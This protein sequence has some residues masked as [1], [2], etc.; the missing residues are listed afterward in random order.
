M[1]SFKALKNHLCPHICTSYD[2]HRP[3][4]LQ[5]NPDLHPFSA[6]GAR[7]VNSV[8][9]FTLKQTRVTLRVFR[10]S[11]PVRPLSEM[12]RSQWLISNRR[13]CVHALYVRRRR[14]VWGLRTFA[15]IDKHARP[16]LSQCVCSSWG[17]YDCV[18]EE[19]GD[20]L[21]SYGANFS[22]LPQCFEGPRGSFLR[23]LARKIDTMLIF[24]QLWA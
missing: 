22:L 1:G 8:D 21:L 16:N 2:Q 10:L 14:H 5:T 13:H 11:Q 18:W 17:W 6:V 3:L 12:G 19:E 7:N 24:L 15:S 4:L 20:V 23:G 9:S